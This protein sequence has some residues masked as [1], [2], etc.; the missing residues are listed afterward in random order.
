MS[1]F[2]PVTPKDAFT[3]TPHASNALAK[4][5]DG[6]WV[7]V[8][9]DVNLTTLGG[10]TLVIKAAASTVIPLQVTHVKVSGTTATD[11]VGLIY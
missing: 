3:I 8:A 2:E 9:G 5:A 1:S 11:M 10:T 4:K 7:G 6:I